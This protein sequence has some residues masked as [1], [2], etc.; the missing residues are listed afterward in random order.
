MNQI[1]KLC[2]AFSTE[3]S[4]QSGYRFHHKSTKMKKG[5]WHAAGCNDDYIRGSVRY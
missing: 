4:E 2:L 1:L 5:T 3:F